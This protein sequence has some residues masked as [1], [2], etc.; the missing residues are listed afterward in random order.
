LPK[1]KKIIIALIILY[2]WF[3][4][5][6]PQNRFIILGTL[7]IE[8]FLIVIIIG[9]T[10]CYERVKITN[11]KRS[12]FVIALYGAMLLSYLL[13]PYKSFYLVDFWFEH[14]WKVIILYFIL[15]L[16]ISSVED[17][18]QVMFGFL[19]ASTIYQMHSWLD[20]I[21]GGSYVYQQGIRRM[22]GVWT[23]GIGSANYF[24]FLGLF[25]IPFAHYYYSIST[26]RGKIL[27]GVSL[28]ISCS[29]TIY[30]GT[31]GGIVG[32]ALYLIIAF[33]DA[34]NK[35]KY[36]LVL[37]MTITIFI[38]ILPSDLRS[39]Y[40]NQIFKLDEISF[41]DKYS[42]IAA[43]SAHGRIRGLFEGLL[44][45]KER[46]FIGFG[47]GASS[48][49]KYYFLG[50]PEETEE[51]YQIMQL[52]NF[53]GQIVSEIGIVGSGIF[54]FILF[55]YFLPLNRSKKLIAPYEKILIDGQYTTLRRSM[56]VL[57]VYG[58]FG[59][60]LY[61]Y[62]FILLFALNG[63]NKNAHKFNMKL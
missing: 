18:N 4:I 9:L 27:G 55:D 26:S 58:M 10:L 23:S 25:T 44:L 12:L 63:I 33:F 61:S 57:L 60:I 40:T 19:I 54:I 6:N 39:R 46:P 15:E 28:I 1:A 34:K 35:R 38:I 14:Y 13:S 5:S 17:L 20:F 42:K 48:I 51:Q 3:L 24:G 50:V 36:I 29:S 43:D 49:A 32:L 45:F 41:E 7:H 62:Y 16:S 31:R 2:F 8:K 22:V 52:H 37:T 21:V 56:F 47:P 11:V 59:H 53:Y 30:S